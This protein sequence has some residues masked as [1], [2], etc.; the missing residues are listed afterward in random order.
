MSVFNSLSK[1]TVVLIVLLMGLMLATGAAWAKAEIFQPYTG[2]AQA[3]RLQIENQIVK[4]QAEADLK[5]AQAKSEE[6][7]RIIRAETEARLAEL[8]EAQRVLV[9]RNNQQLAN[10]AAWS[11]FWVNAAYLLSLMLL[12]V[13][14]YAL[15]QLIQRRLALKP[16][17]P[18]AAFP[19]VSTPP[20]GPWNDPIYRAQQ[21]QLAHDR[22]L[23]FRKRQ[24]ARQPVTLERVIGG[25]GHQP[26]RVLGTLSEN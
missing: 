8:R 21:I 12:A 25:N 26:R 10:E 20:T 16:F 22:E 19:N 1:A 7:I 18:S 13:T 15:V 4:A 3:E 6:E 17:A 5:I 24:L 11:K 9:E 23:E 14:G 2:P